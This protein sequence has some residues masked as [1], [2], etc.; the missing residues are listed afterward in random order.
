MA[1]KTK[2]ISRGARA[3]G[4]KKLLPSIYHPLL[5]PTIAL[6]MLV[7][8]LA[9]YL[10]ISGRA[11]QTPSGNAAACQP[12][13]TG[14]EYW[15][16]GDKELSAMFTG[17]PAA[18][19]YGVKN[20]NLFY[21]EDGGSTKVTDIAGSQTLADY[22]SYAQFA[23]D[24]SAGVIK[25]SIQWVMYDNEQ[26]ASTPVNEQQD[27]LSFEQQFAQLAHAHG[28]KVILAPAQDLVPGF[29]KASFD[30]GT[31][32]A[33]QFV[34]FFAPVTAKYADIWSVQ[35]QP[36]E[37]DVYRSTHAYTGLVSAAVGAAQ[38]ANPQI[39]VFSGLSTN[40]VANAGQ[41]YSDWDSVRNQ[42][43]GFWLNIP[44]YSTPGPTAMAADFLTMLP[45]SGA[46]SA[47]TCPLVAMSPTSTPTSSP[48]PAKIGDLN[49]DGAVNVF[50]LSI[51]LS[52]WG[53]VDPSI[54]ANL[55][56]T[57]PVDVFD[58]SILL[59]RWGS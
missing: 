38:S 29:D 35:A 23:S 52:H 28:Y 25:P 45:A 21:R 51:L 50:D 20:E 40:R 1:T 56:R 31:S 18:M 54:E 43:S 44:S 34:S 6:T 47:Q 37:L 24:I 4:R 22:K 57:G 27:P 5:V 10:V 46:A 17:Q 33:S 30:A 58:L 3:S 9:S 8:C 11:A 42:V 36:Y 2:M 7:G 14:A 53:L 32:Y 41:M 19:S 39:I 55:G 16:M 48:N 12:G 13:V 26:W 15:I 49:N 59:S